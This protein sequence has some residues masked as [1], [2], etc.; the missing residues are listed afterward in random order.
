MFERTGSIVPPAKT[1]LLASRTIS[2]KC[3]VG[4]SRRYFICTIGWSAFVVAE[5]V[6]EVDGEGATDERRMRPSA[7]AFERERRK[8]SRR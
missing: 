3:S 5:G 1:I 6:D 7:S 4:L 2:L 8:D